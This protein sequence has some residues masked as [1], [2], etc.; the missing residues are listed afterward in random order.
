MSTEQ[1]ILVVDDDP[2]I[3]EQLTLLLKKDGYTVQSA[4]GRAEAEQTLM[5]FHPDIAIL[6]LMMEEY[7]SGFVLCHEIKR[8]YPGM[9]VILLIAV[10]A[11]IGMS[12]VV[13]SDDARSWVK[14]DRLLDKPVRPE[15]LRN[16]VKRLLNAAPSD[17]HA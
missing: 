6:D 13:N 15:Q 5:A 9:S 12:F 4:A 11:A 7:D 16:E 17:A 1:R 3:V 2:D 14:A 8:L 10:K